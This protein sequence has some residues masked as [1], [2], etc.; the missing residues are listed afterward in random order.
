MLGAIFNNKRLFS[1]T[2]KNESS[3]Q[4]G[5]RVNLRHF[6]FVPPPLPPNEILATPLVKRVCKSK[7]YQISCLLPIFQ[8]ISEIKN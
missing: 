8:I 1:F 3:G 6:W 5:V 2:S 4:V 7:C